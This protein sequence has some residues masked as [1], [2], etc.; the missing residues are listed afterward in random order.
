MD[1]KESGSP[2]KS[3]RHW[4]EQVRGMA[5]LLLRGVVLL[6]AAY[7]PA[8]AIFLYTPEVND[9]A[10]ASLVKHQRLEQAPGRRLVLV[11]GSNLAF[12]IDSEVIEAATGCQV[13]NMGMNGYLGVRLML[14]EIKSSVRRGDIVVLAFEYDN[15]HK[16]VNGTAVDQLVVAKANPSILASL[17]W[18]QRL[19]VLLAVPYVA[20]QKVLRLLGD[21]KDFMMVQYFGSVPDQTDPSNVDMDVIESVAG[22]TNKGDL[23]SHLGVAWLYN[24][25]DGVD[26][27]N[28]PRDAE[29][30]PLMRE[31][32][33]TMAKNGVDV[34]VSYTPAIRYYYERHSVAIDSLHEAIVSA[35]PLQAPSSPA[36]FVYNEPY[37][38]D[39][40]YHLN[41]EGRDVRSRRLASDLNGHFGN[42]ACRETSD[43]R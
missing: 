34:I 7:M 24:R 6:A 15:F 28:V 42:P 3:P 1:T 9:F 25:E 31:F 41:R 32:A 38:F 36:E 14:E 12:G 23:V 39:T 22:V 37:F 4:T 29:V 30:I 20:Q 43:R 17:G 13:V 21:A 35:A 10:K 26:M 19:E 33:S 27:T 40:V 11:G 2:R 8:L 16:S 5:S 18:H